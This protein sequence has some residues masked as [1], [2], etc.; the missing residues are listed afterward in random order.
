MT[1]ARLAISPVSSSKFAD[2]AEAVEAVAEA[3]AA[4]AEEVVVEEE[5]ERSEWTAVTGMILSL[6][7]LGSTRVARRMLWQAVS[8]KP[9]MRRQPA[10][11][12]ESMAHRRDSRRGDL[13]S[14]VVR[15]RR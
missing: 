8:S 2:A 9:S 12:E 6:N 15:R 14:R 1:R 10:L 7:G 4:A 3:V 5:E 13:S 11:W